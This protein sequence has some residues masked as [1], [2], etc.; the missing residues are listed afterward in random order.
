MK[1]AFS[2]FLLIYLVTNQSD[3]ENDVFICKTSSSTKYHYAS[4]CRGLSRC[5]SKIYKI[6]LAE[7]KRMNR[8]LC[9]LED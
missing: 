4:N 1:H 2:F 8:T 3:T 6:T 5:S 7:A 9:R